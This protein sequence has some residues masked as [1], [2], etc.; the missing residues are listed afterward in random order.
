MNINSVQT[1]GHMVQQQAPAA[2]YIQ[3]AC[4]GDDDLNVIVAAKKLQIQTRGLFTQ[5]NVATQHGCYT[6]SRVLQSRLEFTVISHK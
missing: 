1:H 4:G 3:T 5:Q 6:T 2:H